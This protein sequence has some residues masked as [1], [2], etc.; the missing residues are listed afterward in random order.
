MCVVVLCVAQAG[1]LTL[2][3]KRTDKS[4][5]QYDDTTAAP[6]ETVAQFRRRWVAERKVD[7]DPGLVSMR[8]VPDTGDKEEPTPADESRATVLNPRKTLAEAGVV[9]GSCLLAVFATSADR[10]LPR[11]PIVALKSLLTSTGVSPIEDNVIR[12]IFSRF[13]VRLGQVVQAD[14]KQLAMDLY[15][16]AKALPSV[17]TR[18]NFALSGYVLN[19]PLFE[20]S[21]LTVCFKGLSMYVVKALDAQEHTQAIRLQSAMQ[22]AGVEASPHVVS[23]ELATVHHRHFMIMPHVSTTL[24]H[25]HRLAAREATV[26]VQHVSAGISYLH[27]LGMCHADIKPDNVGLFQRPSAFALIDLGS[28]QR[29]GEPT[30]ATAAYVPS[31]MPGARLDGRRICEASLDW[32]MLGMTLGEKACVE[33]Q[34]L[35]LFSSGRSVTRSTLVAH[36]QAHLPASVWEQF[37]STVHE[38]VP[39]CLEV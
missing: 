37:V 39:H 1:G 10:E 33:G 6:N 26:L 32:W 14:S 8:L 28:V 29:F 30:H 2:W 18:D 24:A 23:F 27:K 36:L 16:D 35:D 38:D 25:M 13:S 20:G 19:G 17:A 31:D 12:R 5:A 9:D 7:L 15:E 34:C 11:Q 21:K 3:V 22:L 4:D